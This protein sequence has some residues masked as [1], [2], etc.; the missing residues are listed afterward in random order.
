MRQGRALRAPGP[1]ME[2]PG[3]PQPAV[4]G[5]AWKKPAS[6][7]PLLRLLFS[8]VRSLLQGH[9]FQPTR[10]LNGPLLP[11]ALRPPERPSTVHVHGVDGLCWRAPRSAA[12]NVSAVVAFEKREPAKGTVV[13]GDNF[14]F[15]EDELLTRA[16]DR[17]A[18][19]RI[20]SIILL[21]LRGGGVKSENQLMGSKYIFN[22]FCHVWTELP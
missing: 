22:T 9:S 11:A 2:L 20:I 12:R 18:R 15:F 21:S 7:R 14:S 17:P 3:Y 5:P 8:A 13:V 16:R 10:F 1:A 19:K 4:V 6:R